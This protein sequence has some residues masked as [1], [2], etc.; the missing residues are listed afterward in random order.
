LDLGILL[1]QKLGIDPGNWGWQ[2]IPTEN[3]Q[4]QHREESSDDESDFLTWSALQRFGFTKVNDTSL[5]MGS[6]WLVQASMMVKSSPLRVKS[7]H[8]CK[9]MFVRRDGSSICLQ[10]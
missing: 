8:F 1:A 5:D 10:F 2:T 4:W 6:I 9:C 7:T 3:Q